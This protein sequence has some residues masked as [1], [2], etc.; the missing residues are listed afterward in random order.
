MKEY[1]EHCKTEIKEADKMI[2][3]V[4]DSRMNGMS[5][6]PL[7]TVQQRAENDKKTYQIILDSEESH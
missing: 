2:K 6:N 1:I 3:L 5:G 7:D 4:E